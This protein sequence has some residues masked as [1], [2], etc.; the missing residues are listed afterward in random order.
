MLLYATPVEGSG[1]SDWKL[2]SAR[3]RINNTLA[4][5]YVGNKAVVLITLDLDQLHPATTIYH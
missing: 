4:L 1:H 2:S 3:S 5:E